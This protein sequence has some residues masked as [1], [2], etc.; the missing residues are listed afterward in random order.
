VACSIYQPAKVNWSDAEIAAL[1]SSFF[2]GYM[3][4][5]IPAGYLSSRFPANRVFGLAIF[6]SSALNFLIPFV[7]KTNFISLLIIRIVQGLVDVNLFLIILTSTSYTS[8]LELS[9][10]T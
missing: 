1:H 2:W 9:I 8:K 6:F 7:I 10:L 4:T 5:Q 3:L